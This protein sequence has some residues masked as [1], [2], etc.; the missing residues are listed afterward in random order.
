ML[1][2]KKLPIPNNAARQSPFIYSVFIGAPKAVKLNENFNTTG[3]IYK[4]NIAS[5]SCRNFDI[6]QSKI[7]G[8]TKD[9]Q[10]LG[11]ATDL[12]P[13]GKFVVSFKRF[14]N[15]HW[16]PNDHLK[17]TYWSWLIIFWLLSDLCTTLQGQSPGWLLP[18]WNLL[19]DNG[20]WYAESPSNLLSWWSKF[21]VYRRRLWSSDLLLYV[22]WTRL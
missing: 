3:A 5:E 2:A 21:T 7:M 9:H 22:G 18:A 1:K 17:I 15:S 13:D 14:F 16:S 8:R 4:C 11:Y 19:L 20:F 12:L 6:D 10:L